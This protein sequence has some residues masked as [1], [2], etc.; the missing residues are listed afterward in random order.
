MMG[1][2]VILLFVMPK[3]MANMGEL[4]MRLNSGSVKKEFNAYTSL[5]LN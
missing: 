5:L 1:F 2:S 4:T 3:M